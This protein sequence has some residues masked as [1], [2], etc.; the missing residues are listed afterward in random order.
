MHL[1][2]CPLLGHTYNKKHFTEISVLPKEMASYAEQLQSENP[3]YFNI[4]SVMCVQD[5]FDL[6]HNLTKAVSVLTLKHFK[7]YCTESALRLR[8]K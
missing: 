8:G 3:R 2:I 4:D 5:P 7:Q 1:V 6:S